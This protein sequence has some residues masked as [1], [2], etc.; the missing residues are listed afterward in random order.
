LGLARRFSY[1][2]GAISKLPK[3]EAHGRRGNH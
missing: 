1:F 2:D 3:V